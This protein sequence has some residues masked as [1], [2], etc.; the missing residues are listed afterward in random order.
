MAFVVRRAGDDT[1][2][3]ALLH[4]AN[5]QLGKTQRLARAALHRRTAAQRD[6]QGAEARVARACDAR[7]L[8]PGPPRRHAREG[9]GNGLLWVLLAVAAGFALLRPRAPID[10]LRAGRL[11]DRRRAGRPAGHHAGRREERHAAGHR[12]APAGPHAPT[13]AALALLLTA[14]AALL[15][16]L[17]TNDVSL[18]LLVPLTR[19]LADAGAP[20]A[21]PAGG[22]GGAGRQRRLGA[23]A[24][25]Q[26]AE[27]LPLAPLGRELRRLH[28]DDGADR[29]GHAVLAV[30]GGL[31]AG[32]AHADRA[33]ARGRRRAGA[34]A[35]AGAG[36][37]AVRRLRDRARSAL[38]R[39]PGWPWC[40]ARSC[41]SSRACCA[42]STGRCSRSSR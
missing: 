30:R 28:G 16:A 14:S 18:F 17:V 1:A 13:C 41:C 9:G 25:R 42:A 23:H 7:G 35:P 4:W 15:S 22:A 27:P 12:A 34:A 2:A 19:V 39:W 40:S 10:Y 26:S 6:R 38:A 36:R 5:A 21:G 24:D 31:A 29:G 11:A 32:A 37:R 3:D 8:T 33:Q 20:A